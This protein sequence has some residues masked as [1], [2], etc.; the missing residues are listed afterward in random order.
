MSPAHS[1]LG[2]CLYGRPGTSAADGECH[3]PWGEVAHGPALP[4]AGAAH[5]F[6]GCSSFGVT[7]EQGNLN[8]AVTE[9]AAVCLLSLS[10]G[11]CQT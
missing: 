7:A 11:Q 9:K 4:R 10:L 6:S 8:T 3:H 5:Q 1:N 2:K